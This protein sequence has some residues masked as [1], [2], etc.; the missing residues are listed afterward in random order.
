[1]PSGLILAHDLGTSGDK[2]VLV[3]LDE[4]IIGSSFTPYQT[5]YPFATWA[6]QNPEGWWKAVCQ[7]TQEILKVHR[8]RPQDVAVVVFSGQMMGCLPMARDGTPLR[9][10]IIWAD[11]RA[12]AEAQCIVEQMS[13]ARAYRIT[14]H[15]IGPAYSGPKMMWLKRNEPEVYDKTYKFLQAKD[16][17]VHKLTGRWTTDYSD[18]CGT[19]LFELVGRKWSEALVAVA[20]LD[21]DR[22]PQVVPATT[23]V[24]EVTSAAAQATGLAPGTPVVIGGGDGVCATA[25]AGAVGDGTAYV[26]LGSSAWVAAAAREPMLDPYMRTFTWIHLDSDWYSPNGTMHN[27]GSSLDWVRGLFGISEYTALE[28]EVEACRPGADGLVFL[29]Y[30]MGERSPHWNP[31]ARGV[32]LGLTKSHGQR[33]LLRAVFE[34]VAFNLR[35][36]LE[37][38]EK[39]GLSVA[40]LRAVGGGAQSRVWRRILADVLGRPLELVAHPLE[41][42]AIGAAMAGAVGVGLARNFRE[43]SD[44]LVRIVGVETPR[45]SEIY[46]ELYGIVHRA[47]DRLI[48]VFDDLARVQEGRRD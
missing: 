1:M 5:N 10:A 22:L 23:V 21:L 26:Y 42:T 19:G 30:L 13:L 40:R 44:R 48:P 2:A 14:G 47:Y 41:A 37:A 35:I 11:Q 25:G 16:F 3:G 34:G 8:L 28:A 9:N 4:G 15:R 43:A 36:I 38:L 20:G 18:A 29:P 46:P 17:I 33:H 27:A 12:V 45:S 24:G 32:F 31:N 6:E 7:V 39:Q